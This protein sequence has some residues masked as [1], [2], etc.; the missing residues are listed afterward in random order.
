MFRTDTS[1]FSVV[2]ELRLPKDCIINR[3]DKGLVTTGSKI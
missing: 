3:A 1:T 2:L